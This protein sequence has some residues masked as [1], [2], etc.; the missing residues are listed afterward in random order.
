[1][2]NLHK[3]IINILKNIDDTNHMILYRQVA[4]LIRDY[5]DNTYIGLS[6]YIARNYAQLG[7]IPGAKFALTMTEKHFRRGELIMKKRL[8]K[9]ESDVG[10]LNDLPMN[11][12]YNIS[13]N[14]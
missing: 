13:L 3:R 8:T 5:D 14:F 2:D 6:L 1:M 4:R 10:I 11:I 12:R 9:D 7:N